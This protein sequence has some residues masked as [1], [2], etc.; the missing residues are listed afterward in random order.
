[1]SLQIQKT[2]VGTSEQETDQ[3]KEKFIGLIRAIQEETSET[4]KESLTEAETSQDI[5]NR[6]RED[7]DIQPIY[8]AKANGTRPESR[9]METESQTTRHYWILWEDLVLVN[10]VLCRQFSSRNGIEN[11][12]QMIVPDSLKMQVMKLMHDNIMS[13]HMGVK[14]TKEKTAKRFYWFK[15]KEDIKLYV[16]K[17]DICA[18]DKLPP[19]TPKAPM[20]HL[21]SG[22][23]WDMVAIDYVG[24]F[25]KT[26]RGNQYVLVITDVFTKYVEVIPVPN[27]KAED[28]ATRIVNEVVPRWGVPLKIH[29]DQGRTFESTI[30]QEMCKMLEIAK[31]RTSPRNPQGNGQTERFNRTLLKMIK[32]YLAEEQEEWDAHLGCLA[33][34]YRATPHET[35]HITPNLMTIGREVKIPADLVYEYNDGDGSDRTE[36]PQIV[37]ALKQKMRL[38][39][40][41]ARKNIKQKAARS[42]EIY[43]INIVKYNYAPGNLVWC[44]HELRKVGICP[45]LEKK[46]NGPFVVIKKMSETNFVIQIN[47]SGTERL[48]HHNKLKPYE[49]EK[50]PKWIQRVQERIRKD[51]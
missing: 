35:T 7:P 16:R 46:F 39:H 29:S 50:R 27:Q 24:P 44:L 11:L 17:C 40:Q 8:E 5:A 9:A 48:V 12:Q 31:T 28:C 42:K 13:G 19:K 30:F 1:M 33:G 43:D 25:P 36:G 15:M 2:D 23:P 51:Q 41:I 22:A 14:K 34:A 32:A 47:K 45:K 21:K 10:G 20:G 4:A 26:P 18:A 3:A 38:A 37:E 6:Q 49:G